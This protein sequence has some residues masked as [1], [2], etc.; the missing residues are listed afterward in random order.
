MSLSAQ[1]TWS[2]LLER[3]R[4]EVPEQTYRTWLEP[5]EP[6]EV[7]GETLVLAAP[8][9]FAAEWNESTHAPMLASLAP[10]ALGH[11]ISV[12]FRVRV[13]FALSE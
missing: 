5:V 8:D 11:P 3:A 10:V 6:L 7:D 9:R 4:R 2:R 12:V 1:E 13:D